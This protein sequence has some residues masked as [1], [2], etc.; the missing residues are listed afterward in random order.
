MRIA[1]IVTT[2]TLA[3][4]GTVTFAQNVTYD[5]DRSA[6]FSAFKRYAWV[7][8]TALADQLNDKRIVN[9]IDAQL[10]LKGLTQVAGN[11]NPDVLVAYHATF[12]RNLQ[13]TG[14][15][16]GWGGYRFAGTR[17]GSARAEEIT[18]GTLVVDVV[19]AR[20]RT[21]VWRGK[22]TKDIDVNAGPEKRDKNITKA[23]GKLF[24]NYPPTRK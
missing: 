2:L 24:R 8:G 1:T 23:A 11:E 10:A 9:A 21:I 22:A 15:S 18:V 5:F 12:D 20:T 17:T 4:A 14:F 19:D 7:R 13:I 3:M 6:N 16:S